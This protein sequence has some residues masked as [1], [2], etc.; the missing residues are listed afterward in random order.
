MLF[1]IFISYMADGVKLAN[2]KFTHDTKLV[3]VTSTRPGKAVILRGSEKLKE[4]ADRFFDIT[5]YGLIL[6]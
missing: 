5:I 1:N 2:I 3:Q 6:V 4:W